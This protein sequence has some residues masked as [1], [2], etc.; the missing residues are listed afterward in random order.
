MRRLGVFGGTFDPVHNG[1]L[2]PAQV[3]LATFALDALVFVPAAVPPHKVGEPVTS[4]AHRFAMLALALAPFE[5]F[6]LSDLEQ[7]RAGPSYT[8]DTLAAVRAAW[9]AEQFF[10]L[11]GS[12]SLAHIATWYHWEQLVELAHLV[13]L[14]REPFWGPDLERRI[15]PLLRPRLRRVTSGVDDEVLAREEHGLI[16][17]LDH[18]PC[19]VAATTVRQRLQ[20]GEPAGDMLPPEVE[21]Y[22]VRN[23]LYHRGRRDH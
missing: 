14:R 19:A 4:F 21:R 15:P 18:R 10:F 5:R 2:A 20:A 1:H 23:R 13:V 16:F 12:D 6:L 11:M 17:L 3:A 22:A 7:A 8:V 9:G